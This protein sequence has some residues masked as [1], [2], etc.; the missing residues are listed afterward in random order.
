MSSA[1]SE[2]TLPDTATSCATQDN[3]ALVTNRSGHIFVWEFP[4]RL[5]EIGASPV[6]PHPVRHHDPPP[7]MFHPADRRTF[8]VTCLRGCPPT[9]LYVFEYRPHGK[10]YALSRQFSHD[11]TQHIPLSYRA[12]RD[13]S[14]VMFLDIRD[15]DARGTFQLLKTCFTTASGLCQV[16]HVMFNALTTQ[17]SVQ[18]YEMPFLCPEA[19]TGLSCSWEG[20]LHM[21]YA[22]DSP[23]PALVVVEQSKTAHSLGGAPLVRLGTDSNIDTGGD[24]KEV[25]GRLQDT[26]NTACRDVVWLGDVKKN[27]STAQSIHGFGYALSFQGKPCTCPGAH[28]PYCASRLVDRV[29]PSDSYAHYPLNRADKAK[30]FHA[31][32]DRCT[33]STIYADESFLIVITDWDTYTVFCVDQDEEDQTVEVFTGARAT[34]HNSPDASSG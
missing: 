29:L 9:L 20:Q 33:A 2:I 22:D 30:Q 26:P 7:I 21:A 13:A 31:Y 4:S 8:F 6:L 1:R 18:L 17:F 34:V 10:G 19:M 24:M 23:H 5:H 28:Q 14:P 12:S 3:I 32:P 16:Q 11:L 27:S 15:A 25:M